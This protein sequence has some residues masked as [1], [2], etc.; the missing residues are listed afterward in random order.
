M[1]YERLV[2][3]H[4]QLLLNQ[5]KGKTDEV[6]SDQQAEKF[7]EHFKATERLW[8]QILIELEFDAAGLAKAFESIDKSMMKDSILCQR[9]EV[10]V[11]V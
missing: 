9:N 7:P 1:F 10:S 8:R 2:A 11:Q 6:K 4:Q 5:G 3:E